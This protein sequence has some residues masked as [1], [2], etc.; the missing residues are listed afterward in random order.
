LERRT[1]PAGGVSNCTVI[2]EPRHAATRVA[3]RRN[4]SR[5]VAE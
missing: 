5:S 2:D 4:Y 1:G 3:N